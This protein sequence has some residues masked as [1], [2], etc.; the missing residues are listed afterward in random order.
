MSSSTTDLQL[1]EGEQTKLSTL[2]LLVAIRGGLPECC[3]FCC[4]PY[5]AD[6]QPEPEEAG[7]WAC[8]ECVKRW[9]DEDRA[10]DAAGGSNG[11]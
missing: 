1:P 11:Q 5:T 10:T 3:D 9:N 4:Q 7:A 2:E 8:T 6:R